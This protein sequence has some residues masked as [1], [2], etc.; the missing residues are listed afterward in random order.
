MRAHS[1]R[2]R[3]CQ[4]G[5]PMRACIPPRSRRRWRATPGRPSRGGRPRRRRCRAG[6]RSS[7]DPSTGPNWAGPGAG[8]GF[9]TAGDGHGHGVAVAGLEFDPGV[10]GDAEGRI[11]GVHPRSPRSSASPSRST[12]RTWPPPSASC[13]A[14]RHPPAR[15]ARRRP[16][17][18]PRGGARLG[19]SGHSPARSR[20]TGASKPSPVSS[21]SHDRRGRAYRVRLFTFSGRTR[22]L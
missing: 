11:I 3:A 16:G 5:A 1:R 22:T 17:R 4:V 6:R 20:A 19:P 18:R 8:E 2:V 9:E 21:S 7:A 10:G 14:T 15:T 13:R 12:R